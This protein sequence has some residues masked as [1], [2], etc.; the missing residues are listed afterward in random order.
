[1]N[2][3]Q[4]LRNNF[5]SRLSRRALLVHKNSIMK[6]AEQTGIE[7]PLEIS[8]LAFAY[9]T[10]LHF[11]ATEPVL[12]TYLEQGKSTITRQIGTR[13]SSRGKL[14]LNRCEISNEPQRGLRLISTYAKCAHSLPWMQPRA[15][16]FH[17]SLAHVSNT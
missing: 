12:P 6:I 10:L 8:N 2:L 17:V 13:L 9:I 5:R 15:K 4:E 14:N 16:G 7:K 3:Y 11:R 1:M